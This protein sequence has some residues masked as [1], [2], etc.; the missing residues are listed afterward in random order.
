L[1]RF[2]GHLASFALAPALLLGLAEVVL[3]HSGEAWPIDRVLSFQRAHPESRY[4]RGTDQ[5]FYAYKYRGILEHHPSVL[6]AGSSRTMKFRAEMFGERGRS[7]YNAGGLLNSLRDLQ[8]FA[9]SLPRS[10]TPAV[11]LLGLD[12]WWFNDAV[13]PT[14]R[15]EEEI[16][17]G[18][19]FSFDNQVVAVRWL[20]V[21]PATFVRE[22]RSLYRDPH[23]EAIGISA[24]DKGGGFRPDGSFKSA[25]PTPRSEEE[26]AFVD[27]ETPPI[28]ERVKSA[29]AN[30]LPAAHVSAERLALL[31]AVLARYQNAHVLV[32][33]YLPP[34]SSAVVAQLESDARHTAVWSEFR[35]RVPELFERHGF[36]AI[37][38]SHAES[39]G[40]DDRALS[41]GFHAEETFQARVLSALLHDDRVRGA[42]PGAAAVLEHALASPATNYWTVDFAGSRPPP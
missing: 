25:V 42:L 31:D 18:A 14:F 34:M 16:S 39:V 33:G 11:I 13:V 36:P 37:D 27:R 41:D 23:P 40:M 35:R 6:V 24:R 3:Q 2:L 17:K 26:F 32:V 1:R 4:L 7:F 21:H 5:A 28:I 10:R 9:A 30:F 12:L 20:L 15:F 22:V 29:T 19:T 8:D 38:A